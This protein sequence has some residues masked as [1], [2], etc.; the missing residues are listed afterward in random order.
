MEKSEIEGR[1]KNILAKFVAYEVKHNTAY[2]SQAVKDWVTKR[3]IK[4]IQ[5]LNMKEALDYINLGVVDNF[6]SIESYAREVHHPYR[7]LNENGIR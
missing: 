5:N 4:R 1:I 7:I 2:P 6:H 3:K